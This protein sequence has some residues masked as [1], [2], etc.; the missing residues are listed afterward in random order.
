[1]VLAAD[2]SWALSSISLLILISVI[3]FIV[4]MVSERQRNKKPP[5]YQNRGRS[6]SDK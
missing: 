4:N 5:G 3:Y 1:M 6:N 2:F